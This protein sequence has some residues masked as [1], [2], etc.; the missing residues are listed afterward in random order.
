M[1]IHPIFVHFPVALLTI[2]SIME[3]LQLPVLRQSRA[4]QL[5]KSVFAVL[6]GISTLA[7][8][9]TG[10]WAAGEVSQGLI[11]V[12]SAWASGA[13]WLFM[14]MAVLYVVRL[15]NTEAPRTKDWLWNTK[16]VRSVWDVLSRVTDW[17]VRQAWLLVIIGVLGIVVISVVGALGGAIAYGPDADPFVSFIYHIWF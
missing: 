7:A 2:Y 1:N 11:G 10:E 5:V 9:Q 15:I 3:I 8:F 6:G 17:M 14:I 16:Y 13:V 4:W 12:H